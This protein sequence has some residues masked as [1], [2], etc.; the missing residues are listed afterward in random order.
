V[1]TVSGGRTIFRTLPS[2]YSL[3]AHEPSNAI[4][5]SRQRRA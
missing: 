1:A 5:P 3:Q 4:A 2:E